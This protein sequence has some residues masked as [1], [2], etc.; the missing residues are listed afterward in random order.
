M[1][2]TAPVEWFCAPRS[3]RCPEAPV[4][5]VGVPEFG[6]TELMGQLADATTA[7]R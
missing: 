5:R 1:P 3:N 2:S 6:Q 4:G 7:I